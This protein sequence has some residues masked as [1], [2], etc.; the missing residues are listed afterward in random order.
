MRAPDVIVVGGGINGMMSARELALSGC[1][2]TLVERGHCARE[3][4]WAG[5]GILTPL[6]PWRYGEAVTRLD[7]LA[8]PLWPALADSLAE[9]TGIDP[10]LSLH[11]VLHAGV[12][13]P[14]CA[15]AWRDRHATGLVTCTPQALA[16]RFGRLAIPPGPAFWL[17][18]RGSIRTPALGRAL[19]QW[20]LDC[21]QVTLLEQCE[22][23][24]IETERGRVTGV[25]SA[26]E[27][28]AA[29]KVVIAG[30]PWSHRLLATAGASSPIA[31]VRG[32]ML[33]FETDGTLLDS[34]VLMKGFY[35]IP[36]RDGR[37]LAGSTFE[38]VGFDRST[39]REGREKIHRQARVMLPALAGAPVTHH[40]AGLRPGSPASVPRVGAVAGIDGLYLNA[41][42]GGNGVALAPATAELL[43]ALLLGRAAALDAAPYAP[44]PASPASIQAAGQS[45]LLFKQR[46]V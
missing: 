39:T 18:A 2:V 29:P 8:F 25:R 14:A 27:I 1:R 24:A 35:L 42:H 37:L 12:E 3:A 28:F 6:Y 45:A 43:A 40:W 34:V 20:L 16:A 46:P 9:E 31:P 22:V 21:P 15:Q 33:L 17:P 19:R 38:T 10:E 11:G 4:S 26:D 23:C 36:R 32:Q 44:T 41:G 13:D 7:A 30:G 5:G